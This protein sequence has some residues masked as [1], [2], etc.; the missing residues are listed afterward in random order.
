MKGDSV[1]INGDPWTVVDVA[2]AAPLAEMVAGILEDEGIVSLVRG[3]DALGDV[4]SHLGSTSAQT[5]YVLVPEADAERAERLIAETVTDYEGEELEELL[6]A[7]ARGELPEE[8]APS[9]PEGEDDEDG[10]EDGG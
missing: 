3:A 6:A 7:M 8:L 5:C 1:T 9:G 4:F 10:E 2:P